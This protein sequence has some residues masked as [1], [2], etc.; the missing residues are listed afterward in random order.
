MKHTIYQS[1]RFP[2]LAYLIIQMQDM[3]ARFV[4]MRILPYQ[5]RDIGRSLV[6]LQCGIGGKQGVQLIDKALTA[7][8][9]LYQ[10]FHIL[11]DEPCPLPGGTFAIIV[12]T[13]AAGTG[14]EWCTPVSIHILTAHETN[15]RIKIMAVRTA[16]F[17]IT[18][19]G[20]GISQSS[21]QPADTPVVISIFQSLRHC[22][23]F[24]V[25]RYIAQRVL[26]IFGDGHQ[27]GMFQIV[28]RGDGSQC[29]I[30]GT[31]QTS[32][33]SQAGIET[34][35]TLHIGIHNHR[36]GVVTNHGTGIISGKLPH[37][38]D[39]PISVLLQQSVDKTGIKFR[40][41]DGKQRMQGT[42]GVP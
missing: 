9:Q 33:Q 3:V 40:F 21:C 18:A 10:S 22:L 32:F 31:A 42:E 20:S 7:S 36:H 2:R 24:F 5:S 29:V 28:S 39:S 27:C 26:V 16:E 17:G 1:L 35:V 25:T 34:T 8:H 30:L 4:S 14:I 15:D 19:L 23:M 37:R 6:T 12:F 38:Q 11:R 13:V 41:D